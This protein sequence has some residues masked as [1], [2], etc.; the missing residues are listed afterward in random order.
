VSVTPEPFSFRSFF[1]VATVKGRLVSLTDMVRIGGAFFVLSNLYAW[2]EISRRLG[3][4]MSYGF[5]L[6]V[7]AYFLW[8]ALLAFRCE[9]LVR[10]ALFA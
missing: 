6:T 5:G 8:M 7:R 2:T 9:D 3:F 10:K 4:W 1:S